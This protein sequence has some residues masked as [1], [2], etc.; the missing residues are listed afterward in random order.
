MVFTELIFIP[1]LIVTHLAFLLVK[2]HQLL[3]VGVLLLAS[4]VFYAWWDL[5]FFF[6]LLYTA[7][8]D[9]YLGKWIHAAQTART[10]KLLLLISL[11]SNLG[12]LGY[13]KY[14]NF[15]ISSF[16]S[17][18]HTLGL[19]TQLPILH[20]ILPVGISFYTFQSLSYTLDVYKGEL[21]PCR[22]WFKFITFVTAFPQLVAGPIVR[23]RDL[24]YQLDTNLV[25]RSCSRGLFLIIYGAA[26]KI[27]LADTL[28]YYIVDPIFASPQNYSSLELLFG[29]YA[30][31]FQ[32]FCD[33]S[34]YSD[35][36]IGLGQLFGLTF[37]LNFSFPYIAS[38]P[39]EF[40][41]RW[42]ISLSTWLRDYL[43]IPLGGNKVSP[44]RNAYNLMIVMLLGGLWHG[45]NWTFVVWG[46]LHG[47][48][49]IIHRFL[50]SRILF[51]AK[52]PRP[53]TIF[54]FF[55]LVCLTW[56]F[57]RS[58]SIESA[59]HFL[60]RMTLMTTSF[61]NFSSSLVLLLVAGVLS[62]YLIE[63]RLFKI[64]DRFANLHWSVKG[65]CVY[66]FLVC[67][68]LFSEK[69]LAHKAFIYFQF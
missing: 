51:V 5:R 29:A 20:V 64:S 53:I 48:Y 32:I 11:V 67:L 16:N 41:K 40:W 42:H 61:S 49:L 10:R 6:L 2:K 34:G 18:A 56:V 13:F 43:Y 58:Q 50:V 9:Y 26:K 66:I 57:F 3:Q 14:C 33:F 39:S 17:L 36:A 69:G 27:F 4:S 59:F 55:N 25:S 44:L 63:P 65:I 19:S 1:F 46:G 38:N 35:M 12:V 7:T 47:T 62:H 45:A 31:A 30:Y 52:I 24:L 28:G 21:E 60:Q 22:S 68:A 54:L 8:A 37:P 23:A 15:F